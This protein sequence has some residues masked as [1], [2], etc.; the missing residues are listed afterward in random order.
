MDRVVFRIE[1]DVD[2]QKVTLTPFEKPRKDEPA[3]FEV[4]LHAQKVE[5]MV[6]RAD[7]GITSPTW[8][9]FSIYSDEGTAIGGNNTAPAPLSYF[10]A[11][12]AFCFLSHVNMLSRACKVNIQKAAV[13]LRMKFSIVNNP[14]R[15]EKSGLDGSSDGLEMHFIVESDA[16]EEKIRM[17]Y[18]ECIKACVAI[19]SI[20]NPV[21]FESHLH[22]NGEEL[23]Q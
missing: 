22:L 20:V 23:K 18:R 7:V 10:A 9:S 19:Q 14:E 6:S 11:G 16:P 4:Y 1:R 13:E 21:P 15:M 3:R 5:D 17:V 12:I 2:M 8:A